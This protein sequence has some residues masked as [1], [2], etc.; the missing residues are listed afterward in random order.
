MEPHVLTSEELKL[1]N[2]VM[3]RAD[4]IVEAEIEGALN[5]EPADL[6]DTVTE[7]DNNTSAEHVAAATE[8]NKKSWKRF[9]GQGRRSEPPRKRVM[10]IALN[11]AVLMLCGAV[12]GSNILALYPYAITA[13]DKVICYVDN[14]DA[15]ADA[16]QKAVEDLARHDSEVVLYSAGDDFKVKRSFEATKSDSDVKTPEQAA[17]CISKAVN[18]NPKKFPKIAVASTRKEIRTFTPEPK[19]VKD[20]DAF[21]GT[22]V[23][24]EESI[25]GKKEV[26]IDYVTVNGDVV[27]EKEVKEETLDE[28]RS[29]TIVKG[30]LGLPDGENWETYE[31]N[32]VYKDGEELIKTALSYIGR[33]Q[34]VKGGTNLST[35]VDC[36][37]FVRAIYR[38][39]GVK[40][41]PYLGREG[42]RVSYADAQPGDIL[43]FASH[44][45]LYVG[46]GKLVHAANPSADIC[47]D[48]V[49]GVGKVQEVRRIVTR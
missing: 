45:A 33:A 5:T 12:A 39:Y 31:G 24:Q 6:D 2:E 30:T 29:A 26:T 1:Q 18:M 37:G 10:F 25:D 35:G 48:R 47:T 17:D 23:I 16:V 41:S 4:A 36:V 14:K 21:A 27:K 40:L 8:K 28:G 42:Y 49:S 22:T 32:P 43:I 20:D 15:G 3:D 46:D 13:N 7:S 9:F 19:Y 38:L 44:V 11:I 34:Y